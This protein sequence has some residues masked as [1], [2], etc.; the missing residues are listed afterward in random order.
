MENGKDNVIR[1]WNSMRE[2]SLNNNFR[3]IFIWDFEVYVI[4]GHNFIHPLLCSLLGN[5]LCM[6]I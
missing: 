1:I 6:H 3:N 5:K 4:S 2:R